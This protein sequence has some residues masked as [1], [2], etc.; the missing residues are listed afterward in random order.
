MSLTERFPGLAK[1]PKVSL[2]DAPTR[3]ERMQR[4]SGFT[5]R[6]VWVKRDDLTSDVYGGNKTRK[7]EYL[8]GDAAARRCDTILTPGALGSHHVLATAVH[9]ERHRFEVHGVLSPQ[10]WNDHVE[11]NLRADLG[12]GAELHRSPHAVASPAL[13][14]ALAFRLRSKGKNPYLIP[15]GGSSPIGTL[16]YVEAGVELALQIERGE[17]PEPEAIYVA[18]GSGATA[19]GLSLGLAASGL[20]IP[21]VAVRVTPKLLV[22]H[23]TLSAL[24]DATLDLLQAKEPRFPAIAELSA[25]LLDVD[26]TFGRVGYGVET[27]ETVRARELAAADGI[28]L[29]P[30]YTA[31]TLAVL[32]RHVEGG[33]RARV[34]FWHTLSSADLGPLLR[35]APIAPRWARKHAS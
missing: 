8:L 25:K 31:P 23:G 13:M 35:K 19:V 18:L 3:V 29:D 20:T 17:L 9:G 7:L 32:L 34:L 11:E 4:L 5:G 2:V 22:S 26:D 21:I 12:A 27:D 30:T 10:P 16:A 28:D 15:H 14:R 6:E 1:L 33:R 24:R